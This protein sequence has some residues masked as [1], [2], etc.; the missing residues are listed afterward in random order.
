MVMVCHHLNPRRARGRGVR[1][2]AHPPRDDRRRGRAP[3][4]GRDQRARLRLAGHGTHRRDDRAHV[5]ARVA[6]EGPS[7]DRCPRTS[8][9]G[10]DNHRIKRYVAKLTIN[11]AR[12]YGIDHEIGLARG[13]QARR[14]RALGAQVL[15]H[16]AGGGVQGRLPGLVGDGRVERV[17]D[18]LRA[19][20]VP[21]AV[22]GL[23]AGAPGPVRH[24][25]VAGV[26]RRGRGRALVA[27]A[28]GSCPPATRASSPSR[29]CCTTTPC[30]RSRSI[31]RPT[32]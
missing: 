5:A 17:A 25:H 10:H 12:M 1:G 7:A 28:S 24:V 23:R 11:P 8:G 4:P 2:V 15:R 16:Q 14:H 18:D 6:N 22:G 27:R 19:A 9:S 32:A 31:P 29:T 21:A 20:D 13:G 3:R 30:R 26:D